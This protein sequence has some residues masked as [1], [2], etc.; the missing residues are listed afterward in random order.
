[1][2]HISDM[3]HLYEWH[4]WFICAM[5]HSSTVADKR[6]STRNSWVGP[7]LSVLFHFPGVAR[8]VS[9]R[10]KCWFSFLIQSDLWIVY[11]YYL[12]ESCMSQSYE[13]LFESRMNRAFTNEIMNESCIHEW[14]V[15]QP[16]IWLAMW[17]TNESRIHEWIVHQSVISCHL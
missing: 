17:I 6:Q 13:W 16:V 7:L 5:T 9:G 12:R 4:D 11:F 15:H 1:M 14:I 2:T 10:S 8:L 3:A